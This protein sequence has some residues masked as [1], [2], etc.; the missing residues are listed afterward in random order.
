MSLGYAQR[1]SSAVV[2]SPLD[3]DLAGPAYGPE[4][5]S[6]AVEPNAQTGDTR[7]ESK[8]WPPTQPA[9]KGWQRMMNS[10]SWNGRRFQHY[11]NSIRS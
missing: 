5:F 3:T 10:R 4:T 11:P 7:R 6:A 8:L 2:S 9:T 1:A